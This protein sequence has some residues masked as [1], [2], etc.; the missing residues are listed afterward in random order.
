MSGRGMS[1]NRIHHSYIYIV[2]ASCASSYSMQTVSQRFPRPKSE[3]LDSGARIPGGSRIPKAAGPGPPPPRAATLTR[4]VIS[5][6]ALASPIAGTTQFPQLHRMPCHA[7]L[8]ILAPQFALGH[9]RRPDNGASSV[10]LFI[11]VA[12]RNS[13]L[14][15]GGGGVVVVTDEGN[16]LGRIHVS[17]C[18]K[19]WAHS[20]FA[21]VLVVLCLSC[22]CGM[23]NGVDASMRLFISG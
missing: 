23:M 16:K 17:G 20:L 15:S 6:L 12:G 11:V 1:L 4:L 2:R 21:F 8:P 7:N 22:S 18:K 10:I 5:T 3:S 19:T 9:V 14:V 13:D